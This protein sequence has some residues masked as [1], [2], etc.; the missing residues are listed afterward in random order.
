MHQ[1]SNGSVNMQVKKG[2]G[3]QKELNYFCNI[4]F[5]VTVTSVLWQCDSIELFLPW[6]RRIQLSSQIHC[7]II[8]MRCNDSIIFIDFKVAH[9]TLNSHGDENLM[10]PYIHF[11]SFFFFIFNICECVDRFS[12]MHN[13]VLPW[14]TC[15]LPQY[16]MTFQTIFH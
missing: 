1:E 7:L 15:H 11:G 3:E 4:T 9:H 2:G 10:I 5:R 12:K 6:Q 14:Q 13:S 16:F 8:A